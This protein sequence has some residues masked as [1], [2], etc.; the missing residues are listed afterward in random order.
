MNAYEKIAELERKALRIRYAIKMLEKL[1]RIANLRE[2]K[3]GE[4]W[5]EAERTL[6]EEDV[7]IYPH[8]ED[9]AWSD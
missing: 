6:R 7:M 2:S 3:H 1:S 5:R 4:K 8:S 9:R